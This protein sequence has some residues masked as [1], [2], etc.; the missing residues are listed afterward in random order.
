MYRE[1]FNLN[2]TAEVLGD[3]VRRKAL[4]TA[5]ARVV[6]ASE[7]VTSR[8]PSVW[9]LV[10][11]KIN[12]PEP[13]ISAVWGHFRFA[14]GLPRDL[15]DVMIEEERWVAAIQ[16]REARPR[17]AIEALVDPTVLRDAVASL[18]R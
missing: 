9:P 12:V 4:V 6:T 14:G 16:K 10:S 1:L 5:V 18:R 15:L 8:P 11:S 2:T 7:Q 17:Q 13:I 3:P